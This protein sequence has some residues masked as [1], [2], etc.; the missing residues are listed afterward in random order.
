MWRPMHGFAASAGPCS[1]H[2]KQGRWSEAT[3]VARS[4]AP[5]RRIA[6]ISRLVISTTG[7]RQAGSA[8]A[9]AIRC[10]SR[11]SQRWNRR[12]VGKGALAP[13]PPFLGNHWREWWARYALPTLRQLRLR[14]SPSV[15]LALHPVL[16]HLQRH[17]AVLVGGLGESAV[18]AFPD[19]GLVGGGVVARQR[20]PHQAARR[21]PRQPVAGE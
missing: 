2:S 21:L 8:R 6:S 17:G 18:I 12:W 4:R 9:P 16:E 10:R 1:A 7:R 3:R 5:R 13:C 19:P 15:L 11:L 14:I 20:Q